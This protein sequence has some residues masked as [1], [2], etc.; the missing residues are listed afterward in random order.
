MDHLDEAIKNTIT[1]VDQGRNQIIDIAHDARLQRDELMARIVEVKA[2]ILKVITQLDRLEYDYALARK[3]LMDINGKFATSSASEMQAA[4]EEAHHLKL[5]LMAMHELESQYRHSQDQLE[6]MLRNTT[7]TL[8]KAEKLETHVGLAT[9]LMAGGLQNVNIKLDEMQPRQQLSVRIIKAQEAERLRVA[10]EIH[11]GPAQSMANVVL[12]AQICEKLM[13]VSPEKVKQELHDLKEMVK[14]SLQ[15]VRKIIFNLR[16]MVLDD[17]GVVPTLRRFISELKKRTDINIELIVLDGEKQRL[18]SALEVAIFRIVQEALNNIHKHAKARR[19]V[20]KLEILAN[21]V[22]ITISDDGCGFD[23][24]QFLL[25]ME[26]ESFGLLGMRERVELLEG[27]M[28]IKSV[29]NRGTE[30]QI[31][32]PIKR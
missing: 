21:R 10:R 7:E 30:I 22:N 25:P 11:D 23:T 3:H 13:V 2:E 17:L 8:T 29:P 12:R 1:A 15:E 28:E 20:I 4:Y 32:I 6:L 14:D 31:T 18:A 24:K 9:Q 19:S 26:N 16:P 5:E 27:E